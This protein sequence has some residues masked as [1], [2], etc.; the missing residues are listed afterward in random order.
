MR[1]RTRLSV[2]ILSTVAVGAAAMAFALALAHPGF[3][4]ATASGKLPVSVA[5]TGKVAKVFVR[6]GDNVLKGQLLGELDSSALQADLQKAEAELQA[7]QIQSQNAIQPMTA[8]PAISGFLPRSL[9]VPDPVPSVPVVA[10]TKPAL[11]DS[12]VAAVDPY[13]SAVAGQMK[14]QANLGKATKNLDAATKA[15]ADAQGARD[16]LRPK[17]GQAEV[18]ATQAAKKADSVKELLDAG[19]ISV[20][21]SQELLAA[22]ESTQRALDD[23]KIEVAAAEQALTQ[24]KA[25][26]ESVRGG[27]DRATADLKTADDS[28][29]KAATAQVSQPKPA[30]PAPAEAKATNPPVGTKS[31]FMK[32]GMHRKP[33]VARE[34]PLPPIPVKVFVDQKAIQGSERRIA[35]LQARIRELQAKIDACRILA[36]IAGWVE[37]AA[38]G[39]ILV[40]PF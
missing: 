26:Q 38:S 16:A 3:D 34:E 36:P 37:I 10:S 12:K 27:L 20:K 1:E 2:A 22:K 7:L 6:S 23:L 15:L 33:L 24:A 29:A 11:P 31:G 18:D 5:V 35:D 9:P 39:S 30:A 17:V 14:A 25:D 8:M 19:V 32:I 21:R 13:Q 4:R 28:V 40:H